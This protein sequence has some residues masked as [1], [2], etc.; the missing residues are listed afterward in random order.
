MREI[1]SQSTGVSMICS[2]V[3]SGADQRKHQSSASLVFLRRIHRW[4]VNSPHKSPITRKMLPFDDVIELIWFFWMGEMSQSVGNR[5]DK[6]IHAETDCSNVHELYTSTKSTFQH[7]LSF[8]IPLPWLHNELDG[9]SNRQCLE[10]LINRLFMRRSKKTSKPRVTGLWEGNSAVTGELHAQRARKTENVF[11]WWRHHVFMTVRSFQRH[12]C[13]LCADTCTD[14]CTDTFV[15]FSIL[16]SYAVLLLGPD[17]PI[18]NIEL[19]QFCLMYRI[20]AWD[21]FY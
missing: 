20:V 19:G 21:L 12:A 9:V 6:S 15:R 2:N 18:G 3:C 8:S 7:K 17:D 10:C 14:T 13:G 11:I 1:A 16:L 5:R 4:P